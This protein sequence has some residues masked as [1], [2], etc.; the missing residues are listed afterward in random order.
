MRDVGDAGVH[1]D[2]GLDVLLDLAAQRAAA[3]RQLDPD[4][5]H[6]VGVDTATDGDHAER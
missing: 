6:A 2:P 3:D 4:G 5:D 1:G